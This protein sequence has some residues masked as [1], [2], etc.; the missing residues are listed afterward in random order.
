MKTVL[1]E[2]LALESKLLQIISTWCIDLSFCTSV[3]FCL[4]V[5]FFVTQSHK[6]EEV[7]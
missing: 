6:F 2:D 4:F 1:G 7:T 5:C 3:F